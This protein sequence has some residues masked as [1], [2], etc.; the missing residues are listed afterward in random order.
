KNRYFVC[1]YL[2][3]LYCFIPYL[4]KVILFPIAEF[5]YKSYLF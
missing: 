3:L 4:L 5:Y 1:L 2:S